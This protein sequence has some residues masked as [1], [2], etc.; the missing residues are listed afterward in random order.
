MC[1][2]LCMYVYMYVYVYVYVYMYLCM[3]IRIYVC[4]YIY[5]QVY[6]HIFFCP[7]RLASCTHDR[8]A[9]SAKTTLEL[10]NGLRVLESRMLGFRISE[11]SGFGFRYK[12]K[13]EV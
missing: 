1:H 8:R 12:G 4:S 5:I 9:A 6:I 7:Q 2:F 3:Y 13:G 11:G 10:H